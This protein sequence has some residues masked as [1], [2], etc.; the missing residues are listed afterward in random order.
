[1]NPLNVDLKTGAALIGCSV[2]MLRRYIHDGLLPTVKL[3]G[4]YDGEK[5]RRVLLKV[6]DLEEFVQRHRQQEAAL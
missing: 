2:W 1:V 5:S 4:R 3:P 6:S